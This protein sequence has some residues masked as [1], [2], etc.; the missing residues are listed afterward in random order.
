Y[1]HSLALQGRHVQTVETE[2]VPKLFPNQA[3]IPFNLNRNAYYAVTV[4]GG[5][6]YRYLVSHITSPYEDGMIP[7]LAHQV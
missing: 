4:K 2:T 6:I 3:N 5:K 7:C 1:V